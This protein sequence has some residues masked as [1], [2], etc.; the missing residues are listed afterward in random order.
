[1]DV[2]A[3]LARA[4]EGRY[5]IDR[6][7]GRGGMALVFLAQDLKHGRRVAVKVLR[8]ELSA[9]VGAALRSRWS[10]PS[11]SIRTSFPVTR[12]CEGLLGYVMAYVTVS[13]CV[14]V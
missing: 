13:P 12:R 14:S 5:R 10:R 11:S 1:M 8:P 4:L 6:E 7:L 9:A 2:A 3:H